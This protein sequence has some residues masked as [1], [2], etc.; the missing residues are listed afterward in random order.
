ML[1]MC[2]DMK[3][4]L[5]GMIAAGIMG[6][7]CLLWSNH[8]Y[9][10]AIRD[11]RRKDKPKAKWT[12]QMLEE[13]RIRT[14]ENADS[15]VR[16]RMSE[17][18]QAG[19][20]VGHLYQ[21]VN[22]A[23]CACVVL[24]AAAGY[25]VMQYQYERYVLWQHGLL[26]G[27]VAAGLLMLRF[28]MDLSD[29]EELVVDSWRDYFENRPA[30]EHLSETE[31]EREGTAGVVSCDRGGTGSAEKEEREAGRAA[32]KDG[33]ADCA[34]RKR[35]SGSRSFGQSVCRGTYSGRRKTIPGSNPGV[36]ELR[37]ELSAPG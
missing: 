18:R 22:I 7:W 21:C 31:R 12:S 3:L 5:Y 33:G 16:V 10:T 34:D 1:Q 20:S 32:G 9:N 27:C 25:G 14:I 23:L 36:F 17:G 26:A 24:F 8:F 4:F 29:K 28:C 37:F 2:I 19:V 6:I 35:N 13:S 30:G 11:L 15:F